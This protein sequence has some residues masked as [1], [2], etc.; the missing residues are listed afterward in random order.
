MATESR[1]R[2][3]REVDYPTGD[4]KPVG[5]TPIHR[6]NLLGLIEVLRRHFAGRRDV[7]ISGNMF[8]YYVRGDKWKHVS[9]DVF[10]VRDLPD[11]DRDAYFLWEEGKGPD[12]VFEFTS[13]STRDEDLKTKFALYRDTLQVPEYFLFDPKDEY[14]KP[15]LQGF[16][17]IGDQYVPIEPVAGR[18]PSEILGLHLERSGTDLR[19]YDPALGHWVLTPHEALEESET[20]RQRA[21]TERQRAETERQRAETER[22]R[23]ETERRQLAEQLRQSE[24]A[25]RATDAELEQLRQE[26]DALRRELRTEDD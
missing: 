26:L 13:R 14:L 21:E 25:R 2:T 11:K 17:L 22:Q 18:L 19:L 5:E 4:G 7:Y 6:D 10:V 23:A 15:S 8:L 12:V 20:E 3:P 16:R 24:D 9:P 1:T